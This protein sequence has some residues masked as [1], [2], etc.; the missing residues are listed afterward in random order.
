MELIFFAY[1]Y[2]QRDSRTN[3]GMKTATTITLTLITAQLLNAQPQ[4]CNWVLG[5]CAVEVTSKGVEDVKKLKNNYARGVRNDVFSVSD[6]DGNLSVLGNNFVIM[7]KDENELAATNWKESYG[8]SISIISPSNNQHVVVFISTIQY[9]YFFNNHPSTSMYVIDTKESKIIS[10]TEIDK[11]NNKFIYAVPSDDN[12]SIWLF[13]SN[14]ES[15]IQVY[16]IDCNYQ[17][18]LNSSFDSGNLIAIENW[19]SIRATENYDKIFYYN[20]S[21]NSLCSIDFD[22]G[23]GML[24]NIK[25]YKCP[26]LISFELTSTDKYIIAA[27]EQFK[28]IAKY[29]VASLSEKLEQ[30]NPVEKAAFVVTDM[31][32]GPDGNIYTLYNGNLGVIEN[33]D[34]E[35]LTVKWIMNSKRIVNQ[36]PN[37]PRIAVF[38]NCPDM[39]TPAVR[40]SSVIKK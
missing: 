8:R 4:Y 22:S 36:F 35:G 32:L 13:L 39:E 30:Q 27:V 3:K 24:S 6:S 25:E 31:K 10:K 18:R 12:S 5:D 21:I 40:W 23:K 28:E 34:R 26:S 1:I 17:C 9:D 20:N 7:D 14:Y 2:L 11:K 38:H 29:E 19:Q 33:P 15:K 37:Y 16:K